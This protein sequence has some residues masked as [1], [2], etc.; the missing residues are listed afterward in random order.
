M[1]KSQSACVIC[2][3]YKTKLFLKGERCNGPKCAM[4]RRPYGPGIHGQDRKRLTE[5][6]M[7]LAEK[8]KAKAIYGLRERQFR[9]YVD[10][11]QKSKQDTGEILIQNLET[12]LDNVIYRLGFANSRSEARKIVLYGKILVN[13]KKVNI[14]SYK[15][16]AK[17]VIKP[18]KD[19]KINKTELPVWLNLKNKEGE[20]VKMPE[21]SDINLIF[22]IDSII[23]FYSR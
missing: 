19:I 20:I 4:T 16:K 18:K 8:Q 15:V 17:D 7:Q 6:G 9:N 10:D 23:E 1:R 11:A 5:Y 3:R 13:D 22:S 21:K 14:P 12:R 2:R